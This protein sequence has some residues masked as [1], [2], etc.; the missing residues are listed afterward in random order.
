MLIRVKSILFRFTVRRLLDHSNSFMQSICGESMRS[1]QIILKLYLD[2][3]FVI[4]FDYLS[5]SSV[6]P[7][8]LVVE[9]SQI[10]I[11]LTWHHGV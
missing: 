9:H 10:K 2:C 7:L 1:Y 8:V 4:Q 11:H 5:F 6:I 3:Y